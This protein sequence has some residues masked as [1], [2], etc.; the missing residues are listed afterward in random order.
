MTKT[1]NLYNLE[2]EF[3]KFL[4]KGNF[5]RITISNYLVDFR[6]FLSWFIFLL[7]QQ[8]LQF[9]LEYFSTETFA[10]Y[11][12]YLRSLKTPL[13]TA[14][15]RLSTLRTFMRF[16]VV[17]EIVP[18]SSFSSQ[19]NNIKI[20]KNRLNLKSWWSFRRLYPVFFSFFLG[21][22][23]FAL[24]ISAPLLLATK[25]IFN[26]TQNGLLPA[27]DNPTLVSSI[28]QITQ[29]STSADLLTIPIIDQQ[30]NL[31][32]TAP[33]PKIIGYNGT[34]GIE[35]PQL[36]L[37]SLK[38]GSLNLET[39][40]GS[41]NFIFDGQRPPLPF[42]AAFN[43]FANQITSGAVIHA[44]STAKTDKV[45]LLELQSGSPAETRFSVDA[46]GNVYIKGNI[47]L[48]GNLI[49]NPESTIFGTL[50]SQTAT[51]SASN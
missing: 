36:N 29:A 39:E 17:Q 45:R 47:I 50:T 16:L 41:L 43:F 42:D 40:S 33:Y 32:L 28:T 6:H 20:G 8:G 48:E 49:V 1:Y 51:S 13:K 37:K 24:L 10:L 7:K 3:K 38:N 18:G 44:Q 23:I 27:N 26:S 12:K 31:N 35:A 30:G 15:R 21:L 25:N 9:E 5:S 19:I 46:E 34:L 22:I 14:N 2:P 4:E 11:E